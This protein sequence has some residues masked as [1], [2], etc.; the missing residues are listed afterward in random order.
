MLSWTFRYHLQTPERI[1][2]ALL[3]M[4]FAKFRKSPVMTGDRKLSLAQLLPNRSN[5]LRVLN[6]T[7]VTYMYN[8][9]Y[10]VTGRAIVRKL[11]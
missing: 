7:S 5:A 10:N 9:Q 1:Y 11:T 2:F 3:G 6:F 8:S 4:E